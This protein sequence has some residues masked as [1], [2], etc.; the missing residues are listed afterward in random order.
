MCDTYI[1]QSPLDADQVINVITLALVLSHQGR[2]DSVGCVVLLACPAL[3]LWIADQV[4]NDGCV[5]TLAFDSSPI[6][7][8]GDSVGCVVLLACPALPLWIADQVRNDGRV[9]PSDPSVRHWD[10]P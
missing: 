8:E 3:P 5:I 4:R 6:K 7:G 1:P 2:G 10:R 9:S